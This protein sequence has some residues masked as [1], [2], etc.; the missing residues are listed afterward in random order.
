MSDLYWA[1][2]KGKK[3]EYEPAKAIACLNRSAKF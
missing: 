1:T 3:L 2:E